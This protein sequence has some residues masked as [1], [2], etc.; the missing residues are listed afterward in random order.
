MFTQYVKHETLRN[1]YNMLPWQH[2]TYDGVYWCHQ[3][4]HQVYT[5]DTDKIYKFGIRP[6]AEMLIPLRFW[7]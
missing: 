7:V 3:C 2:I 4:M 6:V 1:I 5:S